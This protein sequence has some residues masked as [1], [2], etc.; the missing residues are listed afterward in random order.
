M[1]HR[2]RFKQSISL[3]DRLSAFITAM[4]ASA[5]ITPPGPERDEMLK[6]VQAAQTA[7]EIDG[8]TN[9]HDLQPPK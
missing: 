5:D 6:K 2:R 1:S 8:W 4:Q 3:K 7:V 9:S